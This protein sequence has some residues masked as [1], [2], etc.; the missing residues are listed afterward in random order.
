[1]QYRRLG[2]SGVKLSEISLGSWR[3]FGHSVDRAEAEKLIDFAYESG[4]NY[5]D[6]SDNYESG[7]A[8]RFIG[9]ILRK[10][11]RDSFVVGTKVCSIT[12]PH[13]NGS[14]LSRKH[15]R[16]SCDAS[17]KRLGLEYIDLY[18]CHRIDPETSMDE[19]LR[20]LDDLVRA[21]KIL[22][23]GISHEFPDL[24]QVQDSVHTTERYGLHPIVSNQQQYHLLDRR[25]ENEVM[26]YGASRGIGHLI[27]SPLAQGVLTGKYRPGKAEETESVRLSLG[28]GK[29][30]RELSAWLSEEVLSRIEQLG[31]IAEEERV[32]LT[33]LTLAWTLS[34]PEV[35]SCIVGASSVTQLD[36]N[37]RASGIAL[38]AETVSRMEAIMTV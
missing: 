24:G 28:K 22:Y 35:T 10:Y 30:K 38:S 21:G 5:Y 16:D 36:E 37:I 14:G 2:N 4:V 32:S 18:Q 15:I 17:L 13:A 34:H 19:T 8:E 29:V 20:T 1:M 26:P 11:S 9:S 31:E 23:Y 33:Q 27:Y 12:A 25:L 3:S 6:T 7:Q